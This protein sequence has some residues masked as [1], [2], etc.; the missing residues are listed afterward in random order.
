[1]LWMCVSVLVRLYPNSGVF[2][3]GSAASW[4][5]LEI[6]QGSITRFLK[7]IIPKHFHFFS[8]FTN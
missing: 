2:N 1:M 8:C 3:S 7:E 6:L 5:S 4:E